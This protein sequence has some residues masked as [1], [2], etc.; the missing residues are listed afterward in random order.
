MKVTNTKKKE[1]KV[2]TESSNFQLLST[3]VYKLKYN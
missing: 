2:T 1:E 3:Y